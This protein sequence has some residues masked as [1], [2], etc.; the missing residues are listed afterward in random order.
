MTIYEKIETA[1][2]KIA[3]HI[4]D[5]NAKTGAS[6][7]TLQQAVSRL[8]DGYHI[9]DLPIN[10]KAVSFTEFTMTSDQQDDFKIPHTLGEKPA[11]AFLWDVSENA[12][13]RNNPANAGGIV[14][15]I[16][17]CR[18]YLYGNT[19]GR[20]SSGDLN[21]WPGMNGYIVGFSMYAE[22]TS[23][24]CN[25][26]WR[27]GPYGKLMAGHTYRMIAISLKEENE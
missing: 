19:F 16:L 7:T 24:Y 21:M 2:S 4:T 26:L 23:T 6:D 11:F 8:I 14:H 20:T 17:D 25:F 10:V 5:S 15:A 12:G 13:L 9:S 18:S 1:A 27:G 22:A 3:E